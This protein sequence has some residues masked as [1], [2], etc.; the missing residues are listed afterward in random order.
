MR[1][2]LSAL[3]R[4]SKLHGLAWPLNMEAS[5]LTRAFFRVYKDEKAVPSLRKAAYT[6]VLFS[7]ARAHYVKLHSII[8]SL[9]VANLNR[10]DLFNRNEWY[11]WFVRSSEADAHRF[12]NENEKLTRSTA[13][14]AATLTV[15]QASEMTSC[16]G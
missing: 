3:P 2:F 10:R 6:D 13:K 12:R 1:P 11:F 5:L 16:L 9:V 15:F 7:L 14:F 8:L 4:S